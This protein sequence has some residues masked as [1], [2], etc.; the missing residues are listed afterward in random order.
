MTTQL[1]PPRIVS[2]PF[3][4]FAVWDEVFAELFP[5][6]VGGEGGCEHVLQLDDA[7]ALPCYSV[8]DDQCAW[9]GI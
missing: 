3:D 2:E 1:L 6:R 5:C 7:L 8:L 9:S 4:Q